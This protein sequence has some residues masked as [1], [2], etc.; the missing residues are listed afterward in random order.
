M[1]QL[2]YSVAC[3][4]DGCIAG[5]NGEYDWIPMD[6]DIDFAALYASFSAIV[7]GRRSYDEYSP[8]K[9]RRRHRK[10]P[11]T[12]TRGRCPRARARV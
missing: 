1:R 7:M 3:S 12:S 10:C 11:S 5:P 8:R 9:A 2:R 4:L 6:P